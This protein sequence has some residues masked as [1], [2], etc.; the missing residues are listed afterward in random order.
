MVMKKSFA[1][2]KS[3][4]VPPGIVV[5]INSRTGKD[6]VKTR[7]PN[8]MIDVLD[9][10]DNVGQGEFLGPM[11]LAEAEGLVELLQ[12]RISDL[13]SIKVVRAKVSRIESYIDS[14]MGFTNEAKLFLN[15]GEIE[16]ARSQIA[17]LDSDLRDLDNEIQSE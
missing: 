6:G 8:L 15:N 5:T 1:K 12:E 11:S 14:M 13:R 2:K 7:Q 10:R 9:Y 17:E 3:N 16:E 4:P